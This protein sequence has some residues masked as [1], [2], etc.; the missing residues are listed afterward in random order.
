MICLI[1]LSQQNHWNNRSEQWKLPLPYM[2]HAAHAYLMQGLNRDPTYRRP[3][4]TQEL[5]IARHVEF[6][7]ISSPSD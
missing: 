6:K 4:Y 7:A 1:R 5:S 3:H 2:I